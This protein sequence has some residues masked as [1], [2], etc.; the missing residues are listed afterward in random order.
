MRGIMLLF[1]EFL[2]DKVIFFFFFFFDFKTNGGA[3]TR[4]N[5]YYFEKCM[6]NRM[7]KYFTLSQMVQVVGELGDWMLPQIS[8]GTKV[9]LANR[10][11]N[12]IERASPHQGQRC[13]EANQVSL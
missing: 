10:F 5:N 13:G 2:G 12:A 7:R 3:S 6:A 4:T 11:R 8:S 9:S 1:Q